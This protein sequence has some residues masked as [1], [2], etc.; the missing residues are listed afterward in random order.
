MNKKMYHFLLLPGDLIVFTDQLSAQWRNI[1]SPRDPLFA[2]I[3]G[4]NNRLFSGSKGS[5][6]W[7]SNNGEAGF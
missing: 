1:P 2:M 3:M 4:S 6:S 5:W 7:I